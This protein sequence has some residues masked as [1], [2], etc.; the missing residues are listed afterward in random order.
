[1]PYR[2]AFDIRQFTNRQIRYIRPPSPPWFL[3][4]K[5]AYSLV[6]RSQSMHALVSTV[7]LQICSDICHIHSDVLVTESM[8]TR[9]YLWCA[10]DKC[11]LY[12]DGLVRER[13][14]SRAL[15]IKLHFSCTNPSI[16]DHINMECRWEHFGKYDPII[17]RFDY[18]KS[19]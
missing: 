4:G 5:I 9:W 15:A 7:Q 18:I 11:R 12:I 14:N 19:L 10:N 17:N 3:S 13:R 2:L 6:G 16:S 1:M 8:K